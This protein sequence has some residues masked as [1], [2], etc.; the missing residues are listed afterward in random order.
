MFCSK[1]GHEIPADAKFCPACGNRNEQAPAP[2]VGQPDSP[3]NPASTPPQTPPE[4]LPWQP[5]AIVGASAAQPPL[6]W[7]PATDAAPEAPQTPPSWPI[8]P[9][10]EASQTPPVWQSGPGTTPAGP[11]A[12]QWQSPYPG[13]NAGQPLYTGQDPQKPQGSDN[14]KVIILIVAI[15]AVLIIA[16]IIATIIFL[17]QRNRDRDDSET[18]RTTVEETTRE[19]RET[20]TRETEETTQ[21]TTTVVETTQPTTETVPE[22]TSP[23][24]PAVQT[25]VVPDEIWMKMD[26]LANLDDNKGT[27]GGTLRVEASNLD[28][29]PAFQTGDFADEVDRFNEGNGIDYYTDV[30]LDADYLDCYAEH[31][32]A[33]EDGYF[34][35]VYP[36]EIVEGTHFEEY[37][38]PDFVPD[39]V[40][41]YSTITVVFYQNPDGQKG[42]YILYYQEYIY[43]SV[44]GIIETRVD[45]LLKPE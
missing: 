35:T 44:V 23:Q 30:I 19:T 27:Y 24:P 16:G 28:Q 42:V 5:A 21:P 37:S 4:P 13:Q 9:G 32:A 7:Q 6:S 40:E 36:L 25:G 14:K 29:I 1:C 12:G 20:T 31:P 10:S 41:M 11:P 17:G 18:R 2:A 33:D 26:P 3:L 39:E 22:T 45:C 15:A 43:E 38:D 34:M 8:S